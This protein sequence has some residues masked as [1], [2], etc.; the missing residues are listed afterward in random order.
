MPFGVYQRLMA[1]IDSTEEESERN[2]SILA[3]LT[4]IE[5][6]KLLDYPLDEFSKLM[7]KA[8]FLLDQ[9]KLDKVKAEYKVGGFVLCPVV[10]MSKITAGQYIDFQTY[11]KDG[12]KNIIEMLSCLLVPKGYKYNNGY[13]IEEL[14]SAV[15]RD[16]NV[17]DIITL[18]RFFMEC[19]VKSIACSLSSC[20]VAGLARAQRKVLR[21]ERR[22][23]IHS[24]RNGVGLLSLMQWLRL[25]E[26]LGMR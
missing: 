13:D 23:A 18:V 3:I 21:R 7:S 19:S 12:D 2:L 20:R 17:L 4:G 24:L 1:V 9:P 15:R 14:Q 6:E 16:M 26:R 8:A 5:E 22:R 10:K 25:P 11:A